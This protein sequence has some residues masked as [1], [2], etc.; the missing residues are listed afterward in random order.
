MERGRGGRERERERE[1]ELEMHRNVTSDLDQFNCDPST[2][3][4]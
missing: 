3:D 4:L 2:D 1:R